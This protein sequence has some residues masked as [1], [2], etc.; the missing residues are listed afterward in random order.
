MY[1]WVYLR[2]VLQ[3]IRTAERFCH[4]DGS[5]HR[6]KHF[7]DDGSFADYTLADSGRKDVTSKRGAVGAVAD[8]CSTREG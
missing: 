2:R 7:S 8:E 5:A 3:G 1:I 6:Q 4:R